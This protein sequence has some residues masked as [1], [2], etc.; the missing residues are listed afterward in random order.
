MP[1]TARNNPRTDH[2]SELRW[3]LQDDRLPTSP[4]GVL[5]NARNIARPL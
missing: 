1:S 2:E 3:S 4:G 5:A